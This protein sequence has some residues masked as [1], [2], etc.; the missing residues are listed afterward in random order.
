MLKRILS[1]CDSRLFYIWLLCFSVLTVFVTPQDTVPYAIVSTYLLYYLLYAWNEK[2]FFIIV[3]FITVTIC[4]YYPIDLRYGSLNSGIIAAFFETNVS[5]TFAFVKTLALSQFIMPGFLAFAAVILYRLAK[6]NKKGSDSKKVLHCLLFVAFAFSVGWWPTKMYH[7][8]KNGLEE[9][10]WLLSNSPVN[11]I[12]FYSNIYESL[13]AYY[14]EKRELEDAVHIKSPWR[15][16]SAHPQYKN[17]VLIIGESARRDWLSTYGFKLP[18]S[19]FLD[20]TNGYINAGY[21]SAAPATYHSLLYSL[22]LRNPASGKVDYAYNIVTLANAAKIKTIWL[23]NQGSMGKYDTIASRIGASADIHQFTRIGA[24]NTKNVNDDKLLDM[25]STQI[26]ET[27][28]TQPRLFVLHLMGSHSDFCDRINDNIT[29]H[30]INKSLSCYADSILQTDKLIENIVN[31]LK[32]QNESYSLIYFSD[33]GLSY[34]DKENKE[35]VSLTHG[36]E[37]KQNYEVPFFRLSS[38]DNRRQ[39]VHIRR[40]AMHFMYG[41]AQWLGISAEELN[42]D[43]DFFSDKDDI[44]IKIFN[45]EKEVPFDDLKEDKLPDYLQ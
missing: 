42:N 15:Q 27:A 39:V 17:Y 9:P 8:Q 30:Y 13:S 28:T 35:K 40:S 44:N 10:Q 1:Y 4:L 5:E 6:F 2:Y 31:L 26:T 14:R 24:F 33:H 3:A 29:L 25:L 38:D 18:T 36:S 43:Y 12:S 11:V 19:P 16:V 20:K 23:S 37:F 45:F 32:R 7:Y 22:Y 34:T 41:F 21:I